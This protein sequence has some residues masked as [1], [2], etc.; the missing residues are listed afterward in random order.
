MITHTHTQ[1]NKVIKL[2]N[3]MFQACPPRPLFDSYVHTLMERTL[4]SHLRNTNLRRRQ[5]L[6]YGVGLSVDVNEVLLLWCF[7]EYFKVSMMNTHSNIGVWQVPQGS[8]QEKK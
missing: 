6:G 7:L 3:K 1:F 5:T 4:N 8:R 2:L